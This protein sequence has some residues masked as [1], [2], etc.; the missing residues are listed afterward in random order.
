M[1]I[2]TVPDQRII[3]ILSEELKSFGLPFANGKPNF[4]ANL[5]TFDNI[6]D[7]IPKMDCLP[8]AQ[9]CWGTYDMCRKQ[10]SFIDDIKQILNANT[11][12]NTLYYSSGSFINWHT[13]S[14]NPGIRTYILYTAKPG[15]FRYRDYLTGEII[16]DYD[17][18]GWTQRTFDVNKNNLLWHCVYSPSPRFAYGFNSI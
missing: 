8:V 15:I 16:D 3:D 10:E 6:K 17:Y 5:S 4:L 18:V 7:S 13:N 12:T 11:C 2:K 9:I 1:I 14:D